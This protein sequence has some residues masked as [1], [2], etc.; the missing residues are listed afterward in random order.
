MEDNDVIAPAVLYNVTVSLDPNIE[1][2]W[3]LWMQA[4]HIPDVLKTQC[5]TQCVL[6]KVHGNEPDECTY[7]ILYWA[8]NQDSLND[9]FDTHA[10]GLQHQ[11]KIRY[12]GKFVAFRTTM[13][14]INTLVA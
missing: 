6:S 5:F 3:L 2:D 13:K 4:N 1:S 8:K 10:V 9:Y 12:D 11:H 7:S 14:L